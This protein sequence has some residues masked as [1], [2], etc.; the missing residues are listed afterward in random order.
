MEVYG[1]DSMK[2]DE[3]DIN[4]L[5][6]PELI[7]LAK[8]LE[9]KFQHADR[10]FVFNLP[11]HLKDLFKDTFGT[12]VE[13]STFKA[14]VQEHEEYLKNS[15]FGKSNFPDVSKL[16]FNNRDR[17]ERFRA[18]EKNGKTEMPMERNGKEFHDLVFRAI[19]EVANITRPNEVI[20]VAVLYLK[21][22]ITYDELLNLALSMNKELGGRY[23]ESTLRKAVSI[24]VN[25]LRK[26]RVEAPL[27]LSC[28]MI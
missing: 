18:M 10:V 19:S 16:E 17:H 23:K 8:V 27:G 25:K 9:E 3:G 15:E 20:P 22:K 2:V 21:P 24:V 1:G 26:L 6:N 5:P 14:W 28:M 11:D 13:K 4:N 7:E 12:Y